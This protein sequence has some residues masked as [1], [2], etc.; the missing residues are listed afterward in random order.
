MPAATQV[1][2]PELLMLAMA[3]LL[4]LQV[5]VAPVVSGR[6]TDAP[7][8][9]VSVPLTAFIIVFMFTNCMAVFVPQTFAVVYLTVSVPLEIAVITPAIE[10][11]A[12]AALLTLHVPPAEESLSVSLVPVHILSVPDIV[13]A[14]GNGRMETV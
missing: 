4:L 13:P 7:W 1:A 3:G 12:I 8:Q 5:T 6:F 14:A 10:M 11:V 2:I 9:T